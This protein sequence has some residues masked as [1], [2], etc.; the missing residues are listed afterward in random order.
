MKESDFKDAKI[1]KSEGIARAHVKLSR[2]IPRFHEAQIWLDNRMNLDMMPYV[3]FRTGRLQTA[4]NTR[5]NQLRGTGRFCV[6]TL[7]Y[8]KHV[9][10]GISSHGGPMHY[11]NP[12]TTPH[13]FETVKGIYGNEWVRGV[14]EIIKGK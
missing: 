10:E 5:N 4:I 13:W 6:Y 12:L 8:G 1:G 2:L 14:D 3:A 9:Y 11:T 7:P